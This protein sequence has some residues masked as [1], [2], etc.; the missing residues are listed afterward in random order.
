M[1]VSCDRDRCGET[2]QCLSVLDYELLR[3][4][5]PGREDHMIQEHPCL[6]LTKIQP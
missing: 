4:R 1:E 6:Q 2:Y 3:R 5:R